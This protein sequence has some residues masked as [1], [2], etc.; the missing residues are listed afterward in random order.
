[1]KKKR[2]EQNIVTENHNVDDKITVAI[3]MIIIKM[4]L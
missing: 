2:C 1:M 3:T 4:N